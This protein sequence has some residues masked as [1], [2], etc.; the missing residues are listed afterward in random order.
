MT[1][2]LVPQMF[3]VMAIAMMV[4]TGLHMFSDIGLRQN[5]IQSSRGADSNFLN[6]A[7][8]VQIT[9]GLL[10]WL[11]ALCISLLI[12]IADHIGLAPKTSVYSDPILPCVI[13]AVS[14]S[15]VISGLQSTKF[16]EAS[17]HL[18]L[19][20]ITQIQ[21]AA[22]VVGFICMIAWALIDRSIWALVAEAFVHR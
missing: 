21:I 2:L 22:Q 10:L 12:F 11:L 6:T 7:W 20:R 17:R 16:S 5:I 18:A 13:A 9:R 19:G 3:G 14:I 1:R 8:T 15:A 4:I